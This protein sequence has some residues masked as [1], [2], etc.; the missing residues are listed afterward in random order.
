MKSCTTQKTSPPSPVLRACG[1]WRPGHIK[2]RPTGSAAMRADAMPGRRALV[3]GRVGAST[4]EAR[5]LA[6]LRAAREVVSERLGLVDGLLLAL[7]VV[8]VVLRRLR[9]ARRLA[10]AE[11][12]AALVHR[13]LRHRDLRRRHRRG[14]EG[15]ER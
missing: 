2:S 15:R 13:D 3:R 8:R 10:A 1:A 6:L 5:L 14:H 12:L 4:H 7:R 9:V 11:A